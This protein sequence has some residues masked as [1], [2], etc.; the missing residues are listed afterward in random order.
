MDKI[1]IEFS[2]VIYENELNDNDKQTIECCELAL[3]FA[4]KFGEW[5]DSLTEEEI[6]NNTME[7]LLRFFRFE[8]Y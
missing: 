6:G 7:Q 8:V 1:Q 5:I 3:Y 2:N 4:L